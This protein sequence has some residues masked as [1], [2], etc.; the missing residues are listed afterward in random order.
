[1]SRNSYHSKYPL[2][3]NDKNVDFGTRAG[4]V[5]R[6]TDI[7]DTGGNASGGRVA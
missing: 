3:N 6:V 2:P 7:D 4:L 5:N 1:M